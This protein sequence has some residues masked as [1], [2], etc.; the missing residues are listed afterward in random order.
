MATFVERPLTFESEHPRLVG[1]EKTRTEWRGSIER[2]KDQGEPDVTLLSKHYKVNSFEMFNINMLN[3]IIGDRI[4]KM[5]EYKMLTIV[6]SILQFIEH[7]HEDK[8]HCVNLR[9]AE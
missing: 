7:E 4:S 1:E 5:V 2:G 3:L 8:W 9:Y 6:G